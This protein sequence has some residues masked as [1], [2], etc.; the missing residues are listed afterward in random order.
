MKRAV[1]Q[2]STHGKREYIG[3][4][5]VSEV[6]GVKWEQIDLYLEYGTHEVDYHEYFSDEKDLMYFLKFYKYV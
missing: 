6:I 2:S 5:E 4:I 1:F 3:E